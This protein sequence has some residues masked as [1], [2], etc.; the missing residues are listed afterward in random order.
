MAVFLKS[1]LRFRPPNISHVVAPKSVA[2]GETFVAY[3]HV[4]DIF[5]KAKQS[6]SV[7]VTRSTGSSLASSK[8][9]TVIP[10]S[11]ILI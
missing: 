10:G 1:V 9:R 3:V 11:E 4:E 5:R 6:V 2:P 8:E 7:H